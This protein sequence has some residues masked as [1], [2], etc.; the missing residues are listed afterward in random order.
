MSEAQTTAITRTLIRIK[1]KIPDLRIGQI[2]GNALAN[3]KDIY[4]CD[5]G[6]LLKKLLD[7]ERDYVRK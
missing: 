1:R 2:I 3:D 4:Y 7:Y 5:D 6:Y